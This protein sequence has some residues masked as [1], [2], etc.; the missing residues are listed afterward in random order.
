VRI[1]IPNHQLDIEGYG[2]FD[3]PLDL[4]SAYCLTR[5]IDQL[6]FILESTEA[7]ESFERSREQPPR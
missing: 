4:F 3:F 5:G 1:D 2:Q 6:D 7:I